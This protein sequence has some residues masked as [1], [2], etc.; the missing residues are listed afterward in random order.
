V[1]ERPVFGPLHIDKD[2]TRFHLWAPA[3]KSV[4]LVLESQTLPMPKDEQGWFALT[5]AATAGALYRFRIDGETLV[6]DP[7]SH[8][9]PQDTHGPSQL[10]D[11]RYEWRHEWRGRPWREAVICELHVGTFSQAG[12]FRG[13]IEHL[14]HLVQTGFTAI[15]LMPLADFTGTRN[16]GYDGVLLFAPDSAY[17]QPEDLKALIDAAHGRGLMVLLDVVYNH[18]GPDGNYLGLYA[19]QFFTHEFS[20][21]WGASIDYRRPQVRD[22][23]VQNALHWLHTYRFDGLRLDAVHAISARGEPSILDEIA[24]AAAELARQEDRHIHLVLENDDNAAALLQ[25]AGPYRAQWNDDYHHVWHVLLSGERDGYY[26]DYAQPLPRLRRAL[27]EG[28]DYQGEASPHRGGAH[29]GERSHKLPP[30]A[31]VNFL[32]N[33]DQIGNRPYGDRLESLA[34]T[35]AI[36]AALAITLLAPQIPLMFMGEEWGSTQPFPFFC[37]FTGDLAAAVEEGRRREFAAQYRR[38]TGHEPPSAL[39]VETFESARLDWSQAS[40]AAA[41]SRLHLVRHLLALRHEFVVPLLE[42]RVKAKAD[43]AR[44]NLLHVEWHFAEGALLTLLANPSD[45]EIRQVWSGRRALWGEALGTA[46]T[47][48]QVVWLLDRP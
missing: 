29:R 7:A 28:F 5:A 3:A 24:H 16:W 15:E 48:W 32:Q 39:T 30:L 14:D 18:F 11:H 9:Q 19:P 8:F 47:P 44:K 10:I 38:N 35:Q 23:A 13:A 20:T 45:G 46:L 21:P 12:T 42:Q 25:P 36:E 37:D 22:F 43:G 41:Q 34:S 6:P 40:G 4:D 2:H 26:E 17:G 1:T 27:S 31:F 33:H